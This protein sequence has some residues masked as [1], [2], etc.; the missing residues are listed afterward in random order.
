M[1]TTRQEKYVSDIQ[2]QVYVCECVLLQFSYM[3]G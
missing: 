2:V 1:K 3:S